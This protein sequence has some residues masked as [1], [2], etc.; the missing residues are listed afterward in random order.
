[1]SGNSALK[2]GFAYSSYRFPSLSN[3][4]KDLEEMSQ[5]PFNYTLK[6]IMFKR[7]K[8][9]YDDDFSKV[10]II[11]PDCMP[12]SEAFFLCSEKLKKLLD[13]YIKEDDGVKWI[14]CDVI[15][16]E[17][18]RVYYIPFF[19]KEFDV[20]N[21]DSC[22]Y[23][24]VDGE[25]TLLKPVFSWAKLKDYSVLT[26]SRDSSDFWKCSSGILVV[27]DIKKRVKEE[28][29]IG[30]SFEQLAVSD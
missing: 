7:G 10:D 13:E 18:K 22:L 23:Y 2:V 15:K 25:R 28:C 27:E 17:E 24:D 8:T 4:N 29:I 20:L 6:H 3:R 19:T 16:A 21:V 14:S 9:S 5:L 1:M 30:L 12:N 26:I 11:W